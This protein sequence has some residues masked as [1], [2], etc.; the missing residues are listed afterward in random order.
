MSDLTLYLGNKNYSSWS[1]RGYLMA[2]QVSDKVEDLVIPLFR[3]GYREAIA[4]QSPSGL[5]PAMRHDDIVVWDSLAIGEYLAET[6]PD[7]GLWPADREARAWARS[8]SAEMHSGFAAIR[9]EMP[10]NIRARIEK[11]LSP[12]A[13]R[14]V[15]RVLEIWRQTR[16]RFAG[17][18]R[19]LFGDGFGIADC[20]Y[21]PV[22]T[23]FVT[24]GVDVDEDGRAYMDAV[25]AT[26]GMLA[27]TAA[28]RAE[29]WAIDKYDDAAG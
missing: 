19:F 14:D 13:Q 25:L 6:F 16:S 12:D 21:A 26:P 10:M 27:W 5:V 24:Y 23:R 22:V 11:E 1:L 28:A 4:E 8:I 9:S 20:M 29:P 17:G 18:G 15:A 3:D 7:D 2:L